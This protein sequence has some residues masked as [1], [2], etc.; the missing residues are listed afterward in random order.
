MI[1]INFVFHHLSR[2][3]GL[4]LASTEAADGHHHVGHAVHHE[5]LASAHHV[6]AL[7]SLHGAEAT[8]VLEPTLGPAGPLGGHIVLSEDAAATL[9]ASPAPYLDPLELEL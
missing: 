9:V 8:L 1:N 4:L 3:P 6:H 2:L 5:H 7:H